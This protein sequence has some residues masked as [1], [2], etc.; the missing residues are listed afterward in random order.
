MQMILHS[1]KVLSGNVTHFTRSSSL[2]TEKKNN[3]NIVPSDAYFYK[4]CIIR[5]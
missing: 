3:I 5:M 1:K 4:R 2:S